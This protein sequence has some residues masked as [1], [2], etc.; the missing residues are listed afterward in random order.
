M[1]GLFIAGKIGPGHPEQ[2]TWTDI[3]QSPI[4]YPPPSTHPLH[5]IVQEYT[6]QLRSSAE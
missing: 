4:K 3:F 2:E 5:Q 1:F 6:I